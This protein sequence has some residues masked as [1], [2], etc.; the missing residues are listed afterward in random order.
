MD[1][2]V[3]TPTSTLLNQLIWRKQ[4]LS[5]FAEPVAIKQDQELIDYIKHHNIQHAIMHGDTFFSRHVKKVDCG[6]VDFI[7]WIQN[8]PFKFDQ[9]VAEINNE[10]AV[11]LST[12]GILYLAVNKFL[13]SAPQYSMDLPDN[14]DHAIL[15]YMKTNVDAGIAQYSL[16]YNSVGTMFNW[17]HPLTRFYFKK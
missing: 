17:T 12:N 9:L 1:L 6:P 2:P 13:C 15:E 3:T 4:Q 10:I 16:D 7:I 5:W 11:N 14:Y 8:K